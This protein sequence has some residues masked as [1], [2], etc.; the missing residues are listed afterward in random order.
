MILQIINQSNNDIM[1][2]NFRQPLCWCQ[3]EWDASGVCVVN[4][5]RGERNRCFMLCTFIRLTHTILI[6]EIWN[7]SL[8]KGHATEPGRGAGGEQLPWQPMAKQTIRELEQHLGESPLELEPE[9]QSACVMSFNE[10]LAQPPRPAEKSLTMPYTIYNVSCETIQ[11]W[12]TLYI[13]S[14]LLAI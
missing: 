13:H 1:L 6:N 3:C 9:P 7:S 10:S 2:H 12:Q 11:A 8:C 14:V 5:T 4:E